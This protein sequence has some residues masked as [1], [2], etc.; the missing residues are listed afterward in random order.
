MA[1]PNY[2]HTVKGISLF[3]SGSGLG[4]VD[5]VGTGNTRDNITWWENPRDH[6][7]NARTDLWIPHVIS[8]AYVP[9]GN[10]INDPGLGVGL[11]MMDVN[12][13]GRVDIITADGEAQSPLPAGGLIGGKRRW[14]AATAPGSP[15]PSMP[16]CNWSTTSASRT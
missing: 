11:R 12:G 2:D 16:M 5:I 10:Q 6:G 7:G 13:D 8:K 4:A 14:T 1:A 15:T 9:I 3:D